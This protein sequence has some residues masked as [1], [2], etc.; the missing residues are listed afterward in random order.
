MDNVQT[1]T[2]EQDAILDLVVEETERDIIVA[3][4]DPTDEVVGP[5]LGLLYSLYDLPVPSRVEYADSPMAALKSF[6]ASSPT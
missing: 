1:L 6:S 4:S 2:P 5:A 3:P